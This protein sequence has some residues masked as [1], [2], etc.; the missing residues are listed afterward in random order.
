MTVEGEETEQ[1]PSAA[2][3]RSGKRLNIVLQCARSGDAAR[4]QDCY[5]NEDDAYHDRV[6]EQINCK[7]EEGKSPV[8][9]ASIEGHLD[10]LRLLIEKGSE[11]NERNPDTSKTAL[12]MACILGRDNIVKEL[13]EKGAET[14]LQ[15]KRG[16]TALHHAAAWGKIKCLKLLIAFGA[17][18]HIQTSNKERPC[19]TALRYTHENCAQY[20]NWSEA[21]RELVKLITETKETIEDPHKVLGRLAKDEKMTGLN[22]CMEQQEWLDNP[23]RKPTIK[24]F[25]RRK[26]ELE[27]ALIP[28]MQRLSEPPPEK[29]HRR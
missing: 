16:Y 6:E 7:D 10:I 11:M 20:L 14:D 1:T 22:A 24:D 23:D 25:H 26:K 5:S 21:R 28:I 19:D 27:T 3:G 2:T 4:L 12:D 9:I 8:E 15:T 13:L 17:D 18:L 29:P